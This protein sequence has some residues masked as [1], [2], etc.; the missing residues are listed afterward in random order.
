MNKWLFTNKTVITCIAYAL[1][2]A[3]AAPHYRA[4]AHKQLPGLKISTD[5]IE[6]IEP[7]SKKRIQIITQNIE[8]RLEK[9]IFHPT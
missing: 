7:L 4:D 5:I 9:S 2:K 6:P 1:A 3:A 8:C